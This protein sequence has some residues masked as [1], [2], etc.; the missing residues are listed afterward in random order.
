M[1]RLT[2]AGSVYPDGYSALSGV[3]IGH[4]VIFALIAA[5]CLGIANI[6]GYQASAE[7]VLERLPDSDRSLQ[8]AA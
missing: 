4:R 2:D 3:N 5:S 6:A 8:V 1:I 7:L